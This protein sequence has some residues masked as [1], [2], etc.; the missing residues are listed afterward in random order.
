M[1]RGA[2]GGNPATNPFNLRLAQQRFALGNAVRYA[3]TPNCNPLTGAPN[4]T[5]AQQRAT[6]LH[7]P[8]TA[9]ASGDNQLIATTSGPLYIYEIFLWNSTGSPIDW[10]LFQG[11]SATGILLVPISAWPPN[12]G[13]I[14]GFNGNWE[15]PHFTIDTGQNLILNQSTTGPTQGFIKYKVGNGIQ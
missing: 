1:S 8:V 9:A 12:T 14:L 2:L 4:L 13:L 3:L 15:Q 5:A 11:P 10:Q 7:L 6:L